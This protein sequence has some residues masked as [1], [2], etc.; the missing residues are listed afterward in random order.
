[1]EDGHPD[2]TPVQIYQLQIPLDVNSSGSA[3]CFNRTKT[4]K[5]LIPIEKPLLD[6]MNGRNKIYVYAQ[7]KDGK[8]DI[9]EE[10]PPKGW[11]KK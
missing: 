10:A 7:M 2:D 3:V 4:H 1:M 6:L 9:I 11:E 8:F 5:L